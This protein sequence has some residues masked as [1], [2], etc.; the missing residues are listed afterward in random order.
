MWFDILVS[1]LLISLVEASI[2]TDPLN[3][4]HE[5]N[6]QSASAKY[7]TGQISSNVFSD[8]DAISLAQKRDDVAFLIK[9]TEEEE[10]ERIYA[11]L[12]ADDLAISPEDRLYRVACA[13]M[14]TG[15]DKGEW[16]RKWAS[17]FYVSSTFDRTSRA[18]VNFAYQ[19]RY[20]NTNSGPVNRW[21]KQFDVAYRDFYKLPAEFHEDLFHVATRGPEYSAVIS[22]YLSSSLLSLRMK[23][24]LT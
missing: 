21:I 8:N 20:G 5:G 13:Y 12:D 18:F 15:V 19:A 17:R 24:Y 23:T 3:N 7:L 16:A 2:R 14:F 4:I 1:T 10:R 22:S 9:E 6:P 11:K